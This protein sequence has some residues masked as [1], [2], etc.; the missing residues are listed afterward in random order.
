MPVYEY[1]CKTCGHVTT[2]L[3][4]PNA[5]G[6][7]PCEECGSKDTDKLFSTF[8]ARSGTSSSANPSCPTGTCP[9]S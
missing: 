9:L 2:F 4:K 3:E 8:T 6:A 5:R 7:H 1:R